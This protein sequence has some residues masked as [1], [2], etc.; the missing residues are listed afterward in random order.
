MATVNPFAGGPTP[1]V[2]S[3]QPAIANPAGGPQYAT[4]NP[5]GPPPQQAPMPPHLVT[6]HVVTTSTAITTVTTTIVV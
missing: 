2:L 1:A 6:P 3:E 4:Q 5:F